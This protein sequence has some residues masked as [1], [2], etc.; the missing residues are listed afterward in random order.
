MRKCAAC[1][2]NLTAQNLFGY[3]IDVCTA[4][5]SL[6]LDADE[7]ELHQKGSLQNFE[8]ISHSEKRTNENDIRH[9]PH[10]KTQKMDEQEFAYNSNIHIDVCPKCRGIFLDAGELRAIDEYCEKESS[11]GISPEL[12]KRIKE[13]KEEVK[14]SFALLEGEANPLWGM[15]SK[16]PYA[17]TALHFLA[18]VVNAPLS[19]QI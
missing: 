16:I 17:G 13:E 10:C 9:C 4:C 11:S 1:Q 8:K 14:R 2:K 6:F 5:S 3:E 19:S 7:L 12:L 15:V 18:A